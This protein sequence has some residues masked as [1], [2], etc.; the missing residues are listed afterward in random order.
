MKF[1]FVLYLVILVFLVKTVSAESTESTDGYCANPYVISLGQYCNQLETISVEECCPE[2]TPYGTDSIYPFTQEECEGGFFKDKFEDLGERCQV[3][4]CFNPNVVG[5]CYQNPKQLCLYEGGDNAKFNND[6]SEIPE[7]DVG[8]CCDLNVN[9]GRFHYIDYTRGSCDALYQ[10]ELEHFFAALTDE[11]CEQECASRTTCEGKNGN[12]CE[13]EFVCPGSQWIK[14]SDSDKC[15]P[16]D[17]IPEDI[18]PTF[19]DLDVSQFSVPSKAFI[20]SPI[21]ISAVI[22]NIGDAD[23]TNIPI[24]LYKGQ[25]LIDSVTI[26][27]I[28]VRDQYTYTFEYVLQNT[29]TYTF[30][31]KVDEQDTIF[32]S[33]ENN[34]IRIASVDTTESEIDLTIKT[35]NINKNIVFGFPATINVV[36][37]N[38]GNVDSQEES[39]LNLLIDG[40]NAGS[41]TVPPIKSGEF[42]SYGIIYDFT[43]LGEHNIEAIADTFNSVQESNEQNNE[44]T[45][46]VNV[47]E[48]PELEDLPIVEPCT[49]TNARWSR[50]DAFEDEQVSLIIEGN[51]CIREDV[52]IVIFESDI[53]SND[54]Y[55]TTLPGTI[56]DNQLVL[57]WN[58]IYIPDRETIFITASEYIFIATASESTV[59][60]D[61]MKVYSKDDKFIFTTLSI[62]TPNF[63][64]S[65]EEVDILL[66]IDD[67]LELKE[68]SLDFNYNHELFDLLGVTEGPFL[69]NDGTETTFTQS[70]DGD[71]ISISITRP[72]G[73]IGSGNLAIVR[74]RAKE[75]ESESEFTLFDLN[76]EILIDSFDDLIEFATIGDNIII[77]KEPIQKTKLVIN[78]PEIAE[79]EFDVEI[80]VEN[81][82]NLYAAEFEITF[83]ENIELLS[84]SS[85][86]FMSSDE[87]EDTFE[88]NQLGSIVTTTRT[89]NAAI[90]GSG[91]IAVLTFNTLTSG[92][93]NIDFN[94]PRLLKNDDSSISF[95]VIGDSVVVDDISIVEVL[96]NEWDFE[97][98]IKPVFDKFNNRIVGPCL[99]FTG[100]RSILLEDKFK[101]TSISIVGTP[102]SSASISPFS[103]LEGT[104]GDDCNLYGF[105]G[106]DNEKESHISEIYPDGNVEI[107]IR[108]IINDRDSSSELHKE[109]GEVIYRGNHLV[110]FTPYT[111]NSEYKIG[112]IQAVAPDYD[113]E[114]KNYCLHHDSLRSERTGVVPY[115]TR[116]TCVDSK[117]LGQPN[118][119]LEDIGMIDILNSNEL[120]NSI[121]GYW[122][123]Y[124][125]SQVGNFWLNLLDKHNIRDITRLKKNPSFKTELLGPF[126]N[127]PDFT[128]NDESKVEK[129]FNEIVDGNNIN[130][131]DYDF[132]A[133]IYYSDNYAFRGFREPTGA[134]ISYPIG[135]LTDNRGF[136]TTVHELGH[137][138]FRLS[139]LYEGRKI[140][141]PEGV[142]DPNPLNF[143][144]EYTC[145]MAGDRVLELNEDQTFSA[146]VRDTQRYPE[147]WVLCADSIV[148][149]LG[150][151]NPDCSL[152]EFYAGQ[153]G[154]CTSL[155]Y[156]SCSKT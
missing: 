132:V 154:D 101:R 84:A 33:R 146:L 19:P 155:N 39:M 87:I 83:D 44:Q 148:K 109:I 81:V 63:V 41:T 54:D 24:S 138:L 23:A 62:D 69:G 61:Q 80:Y 128:F 75:I 31:V 70:Y 93:V 57:D 116:G 34:N 156:M 4:C 7:C 14:T 42:Y 136:R 85:G 117:W 147:I 120:Y 145:V 137:D 43:T 73:I 36:V 22:R 118:V 58:V 82:D 153:C 112:I 12:V 76:N 64:T 99:R 18:I 125:L 124:S 72:D 102:Y 52:N 113:L 98:S 127:E 134:Y 27:S 29:G 139:D 11:Q 59:T 122:D 96:E 35:I 110:K 86:T 16:V 92:E 45:V 114:S 78:A 141:Y 32:E 60:S 53:L 115:F 90:S 71:T 20:D 88:F 66:K 123:V 17:C 126:A 135:S 46:T 38:T 65:G 48:P 30:T 130:T 13:E 3:G 1:K 95:N 103:S 26:P 131:D 77:T 40:E 6:C 129:F 50:G 152:E 2:E 94:E 121:E 37:Q 119:D 49:L 106:L 149:A 8:C 133:Y 140:K 51:N 144:Q 143:P 56:I 108:L 21:E 91:K 100:D 55:V 97:E 28:Y 9:E 105:M 142:P 150:Y 107:E 79:G 47:L 5:S 67:V 10:N 25:E 151:E 74:L 89:D 15:C 68:I 104:G 111:D